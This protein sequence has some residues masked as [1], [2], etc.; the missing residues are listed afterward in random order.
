M[1]KIYFL[2][3]LVSI[4]AISINQTYSSEFIYGNSAAKKA[5]C[6]YHQ[7]QINFSDEEEKINSWRKLGFSE[8]KTK[9]FVAD[10]YVN[11]LLFKKGLY[12]FSGLADQ[13]N[14]IESA[15][16]NKQEGAIA[17]FF[18]K[19]DP[20][21]KIDRTYSPWFNEVHYAPFEKISPF[22]PQTL[23]Q[24]I[25]ITSDIDSLIF[26]S[27]SVDSP[28]QVSTILGSAHNLR[29][30]LRDLIWIKE[31]LET[32]N[33]IHTVTSVQDDG[34]ITITTLHQPQKS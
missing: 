3:F 24:T 7:G 15:Y 18:V 26:P 27:L 16:S 23:L 25:K 11:R 1:P 2:V 5:L 12:T 34:T 10:S 30:L 21:H 9:Q 14:C 22:D 19:M 32:K 8:P 31:Q 4:L 29:K 28:W 6:I 20:S 33:F 13:H 17:D